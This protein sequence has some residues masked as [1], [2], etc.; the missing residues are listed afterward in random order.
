MPRD[1]VGPSFHDQVRR[2]FNVGGKHHNGGVHEQTPLLGTDN[3][4]G[5]HGHGHSNT[6]EFFFNTHRTPGQDSDNK[7]VK[8]GA[9]VWHTTK[10]TLLS[11]EYTKL[12]RIRARF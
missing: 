8:A 7:L 6:W 4:N 1:P 3:A 9:S 11:S 5:E 12:L 2:T 10:A